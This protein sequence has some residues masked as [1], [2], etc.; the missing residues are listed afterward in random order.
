MVFSSGLSVLLILISFFNGNQTIDNEKV[1]EPILFIVNGN[2]QCHDCPMEI[3]R[4]LNRQK[5]I[6]TMLF[7]CSESSIINSHRIEEINSFYSSKFNY[8]LDCDSL[9]FDKFKEVKNFPFLLSISNNDTTV[10]KY[11]Q[12]FSGKNA[13]INERNVKNFLENKNKLTKGN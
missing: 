7:E 6:P 2:V 1:Q 8:K 10:F 12:I 13:S 5:I 11:E 9:L 3:G 4:F